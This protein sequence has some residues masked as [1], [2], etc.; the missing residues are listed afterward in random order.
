MESAQLDHIANR[1]R[2]VRTVQQ[3]LRIQRRAFT[4][5]RDDD[6]L[7]RVRADVIC[8]RDG[9]RQRE[10][11][12]H[13]TCGCCTAPTIVT[14]GD[15]AGVC[16][17]CCINAEF[18]PARKAFCS[19][20]RA[21]DL[22]TQPPVKIPTEIAATQILKIIRRRGFISFQIFQNIFEAAFQRFNFKPPARAR[23]RR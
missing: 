22:L 1:Q 4:L 16:A 15:W 14:P 23:Q 3:N 10:S 12:D 18:C 21:F 20:S 7:R 9:L 2:N 19:F 5:A 17:C 6:L 8:R 13:G 11:R